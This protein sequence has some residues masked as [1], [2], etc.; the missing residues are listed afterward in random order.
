MT[1]EFTKKYV[2]QRERLRKQFLSERV[3]NQELYTEREKLFKP[4]IESQKESSKDIQ[5][6]IVRNQESTSNA[7]VSLTAE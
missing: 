3:G 4:I 2:E 1:D 5:D 7:L 6:K